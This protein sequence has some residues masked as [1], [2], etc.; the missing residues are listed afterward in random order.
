MSQP[1][2]EYSEQHIGR[3][4]NE[5][6]HLELLHAVREIERTAVLM[7]RRESKRCPI[8]ESDILRAAGGRHG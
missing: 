8:T 4:W 3:T 1:I 2:L 6:D 5:T 7:V